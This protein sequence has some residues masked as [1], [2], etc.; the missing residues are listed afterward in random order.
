MVSKV[1]EKEVPKIIT[2]A[3]K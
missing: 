3:K 1:H 2:S